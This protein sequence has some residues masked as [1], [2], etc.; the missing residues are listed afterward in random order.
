MA[1]YKTENQFE[2]IKE[3]PFK[4]EKEIQQLAEKNLKTLLRLNVIRSEFTLN[5]FRVDT[6]A[7]DAEAKAFVII[8]Y[9]RD[10]AFSVID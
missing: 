4:F 5:N 1:L 10:K 3:V 2:N 7:F 6:L 9:K 8:E